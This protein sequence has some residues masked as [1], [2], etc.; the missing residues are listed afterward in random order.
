MIKQSSDS[1]SGI[2]YIAT[3]ADYD[4]PIIK[5]N[6]IVPSASE[7]SMSITNGNDYSLPRIDEDLD[8]NTSNHIRRK[9]YIDKPMML[10]IKSLSSTKFASARWNTGNIRNNSSS[11]LNINP[12]MNN[13][14]SNTNSGVSTP[15]KTTNSIFSR[16]MSSIF[17]ISRKS[18]ISSTSLVHN[19]N[20]SDDRMNRFLNNGKYDMI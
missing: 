13:S 4:L 16:G 2:D 15:N 9:S 19:N 8:V 20:I 6:K 7:V 12:N 17:H 14:P 11:N 3:S 18:S 1:N 10:N 5:P